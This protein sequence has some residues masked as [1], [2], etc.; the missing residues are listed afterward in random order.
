MRPGRGIVKSYAATNV[1]YAVSLCLVKCRPVNDILV[2][3]L[4][5][6]LFQLKLQYIV[7]SFFSILLFWISSVLGNQF[8]ALIQN[9]PKTKSFRFFALIFPGFFITLILVIFSAI[10]LVS[11]IALWRGSY[12][13]QVDISSQNSLPRVTVYSMKPLP[14]E[15]FYEASTELYVYEDLNLIDSNDTYVFILDRNI[16]RQVTTTTPSNFQ[17]YAVL[18]DGIRTLELQR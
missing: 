5:L 6:L 3:S 7:A 14:I 4:F 10:F 8:N 17:T 11:R 9:R 12:L 15:G 18:R 2:V 1:N 13:A 16:S